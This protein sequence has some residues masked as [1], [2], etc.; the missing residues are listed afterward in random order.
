[1][2]NPFSV[3]PARSRVSCDALAVDGLAR[4][5]VLG[6]I[7]G[8]CFHRVPSSLASSPPSSPHRQPSLLRSVARNSLTFAVFLGAYGGV[9]CLVDKQTRARATIVSSFFG[10]FTAG[11][12]VSA[13]EAAT[14]R[15]WLVNGAAA[16]MLTAL[17][18]YATLGTDF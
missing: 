11:A 17:F 16:G 13:M 8:A 12:L 18:T 6:A 7:W 4:G 14:R 1:M 15:G 5:A 10:G 9:S 2:P 3:L